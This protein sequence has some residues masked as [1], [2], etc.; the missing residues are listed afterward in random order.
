MTIDAAIGFV[1]ERFRASQA[2]RRG[3]P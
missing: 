2:G 1:L 3:Q